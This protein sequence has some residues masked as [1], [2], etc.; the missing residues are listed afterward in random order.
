MEI[1]LKTFCFD[2]FIKIRFRW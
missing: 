2:R 1:S